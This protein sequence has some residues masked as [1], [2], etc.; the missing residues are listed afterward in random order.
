MTTYYIVKIYAKAKLNHPSCPGDEHFYYYGKDEKLI[1]YIT[2]DNVLGIKKYTIY[3]I[4]N[5]G[6][7]RF[8]DAKKA[9]KSHD[10]HEKYWDK[11]IS[12][13]AETVA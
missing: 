8:C 10:D 11:V 1:G 12:I 7:R 5:Y 2:P 6:Y 3:D 4:K 9:V 13:I